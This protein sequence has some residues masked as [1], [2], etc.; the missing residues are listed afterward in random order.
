MLEQA[1]ELLD[2]ALEAEKQALFP[3]PSDDARFREA[4]LDALPPQTARA[5]RELAE[6]EWRSPEARAA[7]D[8]LKDMLQREVLDQ[9]F[10]GMK[11]ALQDPG[12]QRVAAGAQ[13]HDG[14]PQ[15]AAGEARARRGHRRRL[16]RVHGQARPVLPGQPGDGRAAARQ[17]RAPGCRD[18]ADARVDD[19]RAAPGAL[20]AHGAGARRPRPRL[21][22]GPAQR[23]PAGDAARPAVDRSPAPARRR[24]ARAGRRDRGA[25]GPR[26]P[27]RAGRGDGAG[28]PRGLARGRR[29]GRRGP[30]PRP[31]GRRRPARAAAGGARARAAGLP[32]AQGRRA[33]A[34]R[35]GDPSHRPD[36]AASGLRL[37][38]GR[39]PRRPRRARRRGGRRAHG[40]H[41]RVALRRRAAAR[42]GEDRVERRTPPHGRPRRPAAAARG[43]R[44]P[45][46]RAPHPRRGGAARRP[47][48]LDGHERHVAHREDDRDGAAR[49]GHHAVPARRGGD[50]RVREPRPP[51]QAARAARTSTPTTSR[52]P[53]CSTR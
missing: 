49:A 50:H 44:D 39:H 52:A 21:G 31:S 45:R 48:V 37:A 28:L 35:Q 19:A 12:R 20:R 46:D 6:Y 7:Y 32:H 43:L 27:R 18:A 25:R 34:H 9:Q 8:E 5:V 33:R 42:R 16:R 10:R 53:T 36:R 41:A 2:Q 15:R 1:R 24:A 4:Q 23:Q 22:D 26:R 13:G 51:H 29:R 38:R 47:V 17:P 3:D 30:R 11:Q 40:H 14:R